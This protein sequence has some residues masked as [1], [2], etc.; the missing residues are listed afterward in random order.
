[1]PQVVAIRSCTRLT[2]GGDGFRSIMAFMALCGK[3]VGLKKSP[4]GESGRQVA[5]YRKAQFRQAKFSE[6][7]TGLDLLS[8]VEDF[9]EDAEVGDEGLAAGG[10]EGVEGLGAAVASEFL[11]ADELGFLQGAEVGDEVAVGH[12]QLAFKV[13]KRPR[14]D[15]RSEQRHDG[16]AAFFV[17]E[18][19]ELG[20]VDHAESPR[21]LVVTMMPP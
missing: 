3:V 12:V 4:N 1:M 5:L 13:L 8:E 14:L 9:F 7:F 16:E 6:I 18:F 2:V 10:G 21:C 15:P 19:I 20:E 17:D 11:A